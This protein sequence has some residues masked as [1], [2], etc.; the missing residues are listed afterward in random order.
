MKTIEELIKLEEKR[1]SEYIELIASE[2]FVSDRILNAV[3]SILTN[4]YAE[5]YPGKR[6]YDGCEI[7]DEVE[8]LAI[9]NAKKIFNANYANVQ[10]HSGSQANM[11]AY[12]SVLKPGDKILGMSLSSGGHL[13]HG[14]FVS[15]SGKIFNS[16]QYSVNKET[17]LIDYDEVREIAIREKPQM[18]I[19]GASAYPRAIDFSKFKEIAD[20]VG[21]YLLADVAH[22]SGLIITGH[23]Q[24]PLKYCDIVTTTT[25]KTLRGPRGGMILTNSKEMAIKIDKSVFPGTQGGP[26]VHVIAG[27]AI[28]YEEAATEE[29]SEY[30][31]LVL[32]NMKTLEK[33]FKESNVKMITGGTDNHL[34]LIDVK[35]SFGMTGHRASDLLFR[36]NII[37]NKNTIPFDSEGPMITSGIRI[38]SPAMTT[39]GFK[40]KHFETIGKTII[41]I[42]NS[43]DMDFSSSKRE[44]M[45]KL[46]EEIENEKY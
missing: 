28:A 11:A 9:E 24:N 36:A 31:K 32:K 35:E 30:I 38:G 40:E 14:H 22:I 13:T 5:G 12:M 10:P 4:K 2:N 42:L 7:V 46:M 34:I 6:Y 20:E 33:V 25:H 1:Q 8:T 3:G 21:A 45:I 18:I 26:L 19:C 41:E 27:K 23:H 29:F 39:K 15:N 37:V 17:H 43:N 16:I 44:D